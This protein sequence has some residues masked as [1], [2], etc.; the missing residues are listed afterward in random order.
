MPDSTTNFSL[1]KPLVNNPTDA[2]VWGGLLNDNADDLD[3]ILSKDQFHALITSPT[4]KT[5]VLAQKMR[6]GGVITETTTD[7][8]EGTATA[9][10]AID[11]TPLGGTANSVSTT[12]QSQAH[13]SANSFSAGATLSV[14]ISANSGCRDLAISVFYTRT[15][16]GS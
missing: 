11:G 4:D 8:A 9:T 14:T 12:E 15:S 7:C 6:H 16:A 10:F 1:N 2:D 13:A 5:Y 3:E